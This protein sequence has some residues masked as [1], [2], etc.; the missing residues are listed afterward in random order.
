[1]GAPFDPRALDEIREFCASAAAADA[2]R[3]R[4]LERKRRRLLRHCRGLIEG[5]DE[6]TDLGH[7]SLASVPLVWEEEAPR[8]LDHVVYLLHRLGDRV[9]RSYEDLIKDGVERLD[10]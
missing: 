5:I 8:K 6:H 3:D 4:R 7:G 9:V 2:F 1:M 10:L